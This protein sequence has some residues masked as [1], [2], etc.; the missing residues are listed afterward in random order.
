MKIEYYCANQFKILWFL[1][2]DIYIVLLFITIL[3]LALNNHKIISYFKRE[4]EQ[5]SLIIVILVFLLLVFSFIITVFATSS[6]SLEY[7]IFFFACPVAL[8]GTVLLVGLNL[9]KV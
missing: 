9:P 1:A 4:G 2:L 7:S 3:V 6:L 8:T 5:S